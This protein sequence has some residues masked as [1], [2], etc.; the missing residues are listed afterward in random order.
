MFSIYS[1][2]MFHILKQP[3][4]FTKKTTHHS[5]IQ[6]CIEG[7]FVAFVLIVMQPFGISNLISEHKNLYLAL[8]GLVTTISGLVLRLIIFK[9]FPAFFTE[10]TWTIIKEIGS[11][12]LLISLISI[13]NILLTL[14]LFGG[15][16]TLLAVVQMFMMVLVIGLF[17]STFGVMLNYIIQLKRHNKTFELHSTEK[18]KETNTQIIFKAE[19]EKDTFT[20]DSTALLYI[21]SADNYCTIHYLTEESIRKE[22][23][24]SSLSRLENQIASKTIVRTHRSYVTNLDFVKTVTG[25]AQGYKLHLEKLEIQ[26]PLARKYTSV[27]KLLN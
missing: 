10:S 15:Q 9:S 18:E 5:I 6:S 3:Y 16:F 13:G 22:L 14:T 20:V 2:Y 21:E 24:R 12:M 26:I 17:P 8:Y 1:I 4:P 19:N 11:I 27:L 25:N 23:I 7:L